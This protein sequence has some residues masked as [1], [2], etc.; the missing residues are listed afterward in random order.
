MSLIY[1]MIVYHHAFHKATA[2]ER[3]QLWCWDMTVVLDGQL[4]YCIDNNEYTVRRNDI[5]LVPP[6]TFKERFFYSGVLEYAS[7]NFT[8]HPNVQLPLPHYIPKAL[9][10]VMRK[11]I[12]LY[13][14]EFIIP[15]CYS[16]EKIAMIANFILYELLNYQT[17]NN[18]SPH[19]N[20]MLQTI[21]EHIYEPL[22]LSNIATITALSPSY[23]ANLFKKEVGCTIGDYIQKQKMLLARDMILAEEISLHEIAEK[24]G[25]TNY[26]Y[27]SAQFKKQYNCTP[28]EIRKYN[29]N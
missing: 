20:I 9:T 23:A 18:H 15:D 21:R 28:S 7:F 13:A 29:Q 26:S 25:Y 6:K 14:E 17:T 8:L 24:L 12:G 27:F 10:P 3:A 5:I 22:S 19:V 16:K 1:E 2:L 11:A 4:H